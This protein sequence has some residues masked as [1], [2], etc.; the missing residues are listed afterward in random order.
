MTGWEVCKA[1]NQKISY[2][3]SQWDQVYMHSMWTSRWGLI[4]L[5]TEHYILCNM[6]TRPDSRFVPS[7]WE[8]A[9]LCNDV[10]HWLGANLESVL[11]TLLLC[12]VLLWLIFFPGCHPIHLPITLRVTSQALGNHITSYVSNT[13][14]VSHSTLV[15][16]FYIVLT[17][18]I[19]M[20]STWWFAGG[21][22][23]PSH[24]QTIIMTYDIFYTLGWLVSQMLQHNN[25]G[26]QI[27]TSWNL[28]MNNEG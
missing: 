25:T 22:V 13:A 7:Q 10:S 8:T 24:L 4:W 17:L 5:W 27:M 14:F 18:F 21:M 16:S 3:K 6:H 20:K 9:L 2:T 28:R 15:L 11:H 1:V 12:L 26:K 19:I 23:A